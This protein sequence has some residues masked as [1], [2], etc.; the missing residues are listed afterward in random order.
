M[1]IS[2]RAIDIR[3][4]ILYLEHQVSVQ[5]LVNKQHTT[6]TISPTTIG[7]LSLIIVIILGLVI[8]NEVLVVGAK[9]D[10]ARA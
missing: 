9:A 2:E 5:V 4:E 6:M 1:P 3:P 8:E 10:T 7:S